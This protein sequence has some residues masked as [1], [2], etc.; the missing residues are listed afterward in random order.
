[1]L[2]HSLG[3]MESRIKKCTPHCICRPWQ[4]R[5]VVVADGGDSTL[6]VFFPNPKNEMVM[7]QQIGEP[8]GHGGPDPTVRGDRFFWGS[9]DVRFGGSMQDGWVKRHTSIA[10]DDWG[11]VWV[12]D[13]GNSRILR[14]NLTSKERIGEPVSFLQASYSSAASH[15]NTSRVFSNMLE[16]AVNA[17]LPAASCGDAF[18]A[19]NPSSWKLVR[20]WKR[21]SAFG[22]A[23]LSGTIRSVAEVAGKTL[24][25]VA[26]NDRF[27]SMALAELDPKRG[28][29]VVLVLSPA[30]HPDP[31][32]G[33]V[34][35][36]EMSLNPDGSVTYSMQWESRLPNGTFDWTNKT[37]MFYSAPYNPATGNWSMPAKPV[38]M[39]HGRE[40]SLFMSS[41][42]A[43]PRYPKTSDGNMV[44]FDAGTGQE[45]WVHSP[46]QGNHLG[47]LMPLHKL[48]T[49][50]AGVSPWKWQASP[51][52]TWNLTKGPNQVFG[53]DTYFTR[54]WQ[55]LVRL[56]HGFSVSTSVIDP[57]MLDGRYG[58]K[59]SG[60]QYAGNVPMAVGDDVVYGFH[61]EFWHGLEAGQFVHFRHGLYVANFG[62]EYFSVNTGC[63]YGSYTVPGVAGNSYAPVLVP[64]ASTDEVTMYH[65]DESQHA[66]IHRW[67]ITGLD[68][69]VQLTPEQEQE[70]AHVHV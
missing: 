51:W 52:G 35:Y 62:T 4:Q 26:L 37:Q 3:R 49:A 27:Q 9:W 53:T 6:K 48:A 29:Q 70:Q 2:G 16:F 14:F 40:G 69:V 64:G 8:G 59:D 33:V 23:N 44:I 12:L 68:S 65:N 1:M 34:D 61:G 46:N 19:S 5:G 54:D 21:E 32:R 43:G 57:S 55:G 45:T 28:L 22:F 24:A 7:V 41:S 50:A 38:A 39:I 67:R 58:A 10:V 13:A 56:C 31:Q 30:Q 66:G 11:A 20:N 15:T 60:V 47:S 25:A 18:P 42:F 17:T 36:R 63:G